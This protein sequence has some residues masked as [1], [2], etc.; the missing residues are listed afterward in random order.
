M[1]NIY[2]NILSNIFKINI[3]NLYD[4]MILFNTIKK[5]KIIYKYNDYII[6]YFF[7]EKKIKIYIKNNKNYN[8]SYILDKYIIKYQKQKEIYIDN[9]ENS[10]D[11]LYYIN[12]IIYKNISYYISNNGIKFIYL[13]K[14]L[15]KYYDNVDINKINSIKKYLHSK[16]VQFIIYK[17]TNNYIYIKILYTIIYNNKLNLIK[18]NMKLLQLII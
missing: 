16:N 7:Q 15:T 2:Y 14:K 10:K 6:T 17:Y 8:I 9:E 3:V 11:I 12:N 18:T 4:N 13:S 1:D 5:N